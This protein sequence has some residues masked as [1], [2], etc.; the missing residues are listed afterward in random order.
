M[1]QRPASKRK[2]PE[3]C[4]F[5]RARNFCRLK[6]VGGHGSNGSCVDTLRSAYLGELNLGGIGFGRRWMFVIFLD[7][8]GVVMRLDVGI[9]ANSRRYGVESWRSTQ[10][11]APYPC[12]FTHAPQFGGATS[13]SARPAPPSVPDPQNGPDDQAAATALGGNQPPSPV[14]SAFRPVWP[15]CC[16]V[17]NLSL[18]ATSRLAPWT[19][20]SRTA[21]SCQPQ[22]WRP[23]AIP[24][25]HRRLLHHT[26]HH[27]T[28]HLWAR[29]VGKYW[30]EDDGKSWA[31]PHSVTLRLSQ[32]RRVPFP[33]TTRHRTGF[34][35]RLRC[36]VDT[37][38]SAECCRESKLRPT[39]HLRGPA[40]SGWQTARNVLVE[41]FFFVASA[42]RPV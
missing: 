12:P 4:R 7:L 24:L 8:E 18:R 9:W 33:T 40:C 26:H 39:A 2:Y 23:L 6:P 3:A 27:T 14:A 35:S 10:T 13:S 16:I 15:G 5:A 19:R 28:T 34:H 29:S 17:L 41:P 22:T 31:S 30:L 32:W 21:A 11:K 37:A 25:H 1:N 20:G 36:G 38:L 42:F